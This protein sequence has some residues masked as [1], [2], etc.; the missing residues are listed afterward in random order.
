MTENKITKREKIMGGI[1]ISLILFFAILKGCDQRS[2]D[3]VLD[4]AINY[5]DSAK[6]YKIKVDGMKVDVA[7][8]QSLVLQNKDQIEAL[9]KKND[10]LFKLVSKFKDIKSTTIINQYTEIKGD[11]IKVETKI[12]CDFRPFKV[13]RDSTYYRFVGTVAPDYFSIDS[14]KIPN[15]Q[16]LVVGKKK[17]GF[18]RGYEE[19]AEIVNSNPLVK[20]DK[21]ASYV[22]S[23]KK[24]R[25]GIGASVGYGVQVG[26]AIS[27]GPHIGIS[28][29][30]NLIQF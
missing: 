5:K 22:I 19:R 11:T 16:Y 20:T 7:Y 17:L 29:N 2:F 3:N 14:L 1:I 21:I 6:Y 10:T 25:M 27:F 12:P 8:N 18:L 13:R 23:T 28:L 24:K 26:S 4:G 9:V 15:E 30:Y